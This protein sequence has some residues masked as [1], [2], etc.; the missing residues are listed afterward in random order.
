MRTNRVFKIINPFQSET[1]K[2]VISSYIAIGH[3]NVYIR[4]K[5]NNL[6][7]ARKS[8]LLAH[9]NYVDTLILPYM[10]PYGPILDNNISKSTLRKKYG[11]SLT[12]G[13]LASLSIIAKNYGVNVL[14]MS[15]IEKAGSKIYVTA[16]LIP[17]IIGEPIEKYRKIVLSDREKIIGFN[18][19]KTIKKFR[20]RNIYYS[21]VLDDE[22]L[23]P[24]LAKL[25]LYLGTDILFVGIAPDYPVK[26]YMSIIKS[27]ALMTRSK[28]VLVGGIYYYENK[29]SY[30]V[31][32]II[33]DQRG[34]VL[35]KYISDEQALIMLP[36]QY[37]IRENK[38]IDQ[39]TM[40]IYTLYSRLFRHKKRGVRIGSGKG[41]T[42]KIE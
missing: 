33:L 42:Y 12:S 16:F 11:L 38:K 22:I 25:N 31:P 4:D 6:D 15:T 29:L 14:L 24:E 17:G 1:S 13:Y 2:H 39:E 27:L 21:I 28:I 7:V 20:C 18:K 8:L 41:Y 40:F 32:T 3:L 37:L 34:N 9:E 19:G 36:T 35:F 10:Q 23:Y 30:I 26:N 5:R